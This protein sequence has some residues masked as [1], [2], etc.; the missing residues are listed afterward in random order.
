MMK[1]GEIVAQKT[2]NVNEFWMLYRDAVIGSGIA[3]KNVE[4]YVRWAQKFAVSTPPSP[5]PL[6]PPVKGGEVCCRGVF[7][8]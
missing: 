4:W 6:S 8:T 3:E 5:S 7:K 2:K 1:S